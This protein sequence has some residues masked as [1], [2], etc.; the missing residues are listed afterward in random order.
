MTENEYLRKILW[1]ES[2][3]TGLFSPVRAVQNHL[4]PSIK[5]WAGNY[6]VSINPSGS[7]A[8]GTAVS[9]GTDIDFF[10]SLSSTT[11]EKLKEIYDSLYLRLLRDGFSP[12]KQ[13]VSIKV[14]IGTYDVD[15][16]PAKRQ[17]QFSEDHSLYRHRAN[18]WIK[19]NVTT[20]ISTVRNSA[21]LDEIKII[22]IWRNQKQLD[23]PSFYL[24]L[25]TI[26]A[27][28]RLRIGDLANN[29]MR[30]LAYIRDNVETAIFTD[31]ANTT[32]RV[33]DDLSLAG[34]RTLRAAVDGAISSWAWRKI[35]V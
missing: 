32:N 10:V 3:D 17:D 16:V 5:K 23:F 7:F 1:R 27:C 12:T 31:P 25:L 19:T 21:R 33:S 30:T 9:S 28:R 34:K 24:E 4:D 8:K 35:I 20:H 11:T 2:V 26:E 15:V 6:L 13:N 18:T 14:K 29:V 22:K